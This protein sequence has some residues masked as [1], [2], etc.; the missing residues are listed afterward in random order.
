MQMTDAVKFRLFHMDDNGPDLCDQ[1]M[2]SLVLHSYFIPD[3]L[4]ISIGLHV[5]K[6]CLGRPWFDGRD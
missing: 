5:I 1:H 2:K 6:S 4:G 3:Y